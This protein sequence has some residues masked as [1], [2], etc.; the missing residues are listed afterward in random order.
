[1]TTGI[2]TLTPDD[3]TPDGWKDAH[4]A[5]VW[6]QGSDIYFTALEHGPLE[7][8]VNPAELDHWSVGFA[9]GFSYAIARGWIA[10]DGTT[11]V[12]G[13]IGFAPPHWDDIDDLNDDIDRGDPET[14]YGIPVPVDPKFHRALDQYLWSDAVNDG[15]YQWRYMYEALIAAWYAHED[16]SIGLLSVLPRLSYGAVNYATA[17]KWLYRGDLQGARLVHKHGKINPF[18]ED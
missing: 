1:M 3:I 17:K 2:Q 12:K 11:V 14:L 18:I 6:D 9:P 16:D 5:E 15:D 10:L 7:P 13:D 4:P 8:G